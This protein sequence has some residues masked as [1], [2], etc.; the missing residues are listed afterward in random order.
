MNPF[1]VLL[2]NNIVI[3]LLVESEGSAFLLELVSNPDHNLTTCTF[4]MHF[5]IILPFQYLL[6]Q[7]KY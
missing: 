4:M 3:S 6:D 7:V 5:N 2:N 1:P